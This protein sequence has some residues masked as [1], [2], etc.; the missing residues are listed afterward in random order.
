MLFDEVVLEHQ[1]FDLGARDRDFDPRDR[2]HH[3]NCFCV[4]SAAALEVARDAALQVPRLTDVDDGVLRVEHAVDAGA[5]RQMRKH[6]RGIEGD[7]GRVGHG[8]TGKIV[9]LAAHDR[10]G[11]SRACAG[12]RR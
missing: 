6:G 8:G 11:P 3:R 10:T 7:L 1:R 4:V 5:M 2:A 12:A 9:G